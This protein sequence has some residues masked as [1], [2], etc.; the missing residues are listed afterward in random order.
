MDGVT[1]RNK[2]ASRQGAPQLADSGRSRDG[3][4]MTSEVGGGIPYLDL[5]RE[6][7][8]IQY[9]ECRSWGSKN[10]KFCR[11]NLCRAS[12]GESGSAR[13][14]FSVHGSASTRVRHYNDDRWWRRC[15]TYQ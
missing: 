10:A 13:L 5:E 2:V 7:S 3:T 1:E 15:L 14:V 9:C 11:R 4:F 6:V 12:L 8:V